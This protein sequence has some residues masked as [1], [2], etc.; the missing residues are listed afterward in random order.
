MALVLHVRLPSTEMFFSA[1]CDPVTL[2]FWP[3][4]KSAASHYS[5]QTIAVASLVSVIS[6]VLVLSCG[7]TDTLTRMNALLPRLCSAWV[8]DSFYFCCVSCLSIICIHRK[9]QRDGNNRTSVLLR[10]RKMLII[11]LWFL[12]NA[13]LI[14]SMIKLLPTSDRTSTCHDKI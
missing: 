12:L 5:R 4:I 10:M 3:N 13:N 9:S 6:A 7:H 14:H 2:T 1:F 11:N 8:N